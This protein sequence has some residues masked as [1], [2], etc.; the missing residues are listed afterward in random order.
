[1]VEPTGGR[2]GVGLDNPPCVARLDGDGE[3]TE[4]AAPHTQLAGLG[5][6]LA[7]Q[8]VDQ[9]KGAGAKSAERLDGE[10]SEVDAFRHVG[11]LGGLM[12]LGDDGGGAGGYGRGRQV[13]GSA[14]VNDGRVP[15][16]RQASF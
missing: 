8:S 11:V 7:C 3:A 5:T 15:G 14:G 4:E 13:G 6:D 2:L 9:L 12:G 16:Q 10:W 1:M